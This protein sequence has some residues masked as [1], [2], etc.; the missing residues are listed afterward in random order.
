MTI[1][2]STLAEFLDI[3]EGLVTRG[4]GFVAYAESLRIELTG[5]F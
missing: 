2:A 4:L 1:R 3:V 5:A